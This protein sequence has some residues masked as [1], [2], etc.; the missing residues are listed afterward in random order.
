MI[1]GSIWSSIGGSFLLIPLSVSIVVVTKKKIKSKKAI[2]AI[3]PALTSG[4]FLLAII[5]FFR[6]FLIPGKTIKPIAIID[7][8]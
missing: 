6:E 1:G 7:K 8:I 4:A 2:S 5:Y 3:D